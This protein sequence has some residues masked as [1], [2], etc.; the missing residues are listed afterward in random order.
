MS[1]I[2]YSFAVFVSLGLA[3]PVVAQDS[4]SQSEM[5]NAFNQQK[6]RSLSLIPAG[7][8]ATQN[9]DAATSVQPEQTATPV[10]ANADTTAPIDPTT[11]Y[12]PVENEAAVNIR[13]AFDLN[14]AALR[15]DQK[16]KLETLCQAMKAADVEV[17][18]IIGHTDS[19]GSNA[20]NET[21]SLARASEVKRYLSRDCGIAETRLNAIGMGE[22]YPFNTSDTRAP[23]NRRVEVQALS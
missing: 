5:T 8:S 14:S 15:P 18:Q 11:T 13:I 10:I 16:A 20:Y 4:M 9:T 21:L 19:S 1:R 23:E 3:A 17:F 6:T 22:S 7:Q 2:A 12:V